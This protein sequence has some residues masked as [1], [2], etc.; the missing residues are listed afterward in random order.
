MFPLKF[1]LTVHFHLF[2]DRI[3]QFSYY[4]LSRYHFCI[5]IFV[6]ELS[7]ESHFYEANKA[8][9]AF[10]DFSIIFFN[11]AKSLFY[12]KGENERKGKRVVWAWSIPQ[13]S[14]PNMKDSNQVKKRSPPGEAHS[15]LNILH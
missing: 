13:R 2:S 3:Y 12:R 10:S 9:L 15:V 4:R 11:L 8:S 6:F 14:R 1:P 5:T 7:Y